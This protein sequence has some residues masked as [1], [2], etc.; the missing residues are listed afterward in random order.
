M[1]GLIGRV[2][3]EIGGDAS[4]L[5]R[6]AGEAQGALSKLQTFAQ[7]VSGIGLAILGSEAAVRMAERGYNAIA[8]A[9]KE[10]YGYTENYTYKVRD[11]NN[12]IGS[13]SEESSRFIQIADDLNITYSELTTSLT[14]AI[15]KGYEPTISGLKQISRE[16]KN[17]P[18]Q[19]TRSKYALDVFGRS[20]A[21]MIPI[22]EL[23]A[24]GIDTYSNNVDRNLILTDAQIEKN[25]RLAETLDNLNDQMQGF[26]VQ[27]VSEGAPFLTAFLDATKGADFSSSIDKMISALTMQDPGALISAFALAI[28]EANESTEEL[29]KS[30]KSLANGL[31]ADALRWTEAAENSKAYAR[32]QALLKELHPEM[33]QNAADIKQINEKMR[34]QAG[35]AGQ[36]S[37]M[38]EHYIDV[39]DKYGRRSWRTTEAIDGMKESLADVFYEMAQAG[40]IEI[41]VDASLALGNALGVVDEKSLL[42]SQAMQHLK[43]QY[44]VNKDGIIDLQ[45]GAAGY[46]DAV[47]QLIAN[48]NMLMVDRN[49]IWSI[50]MLLNGVKM[51]ASFYYGP[52]GKMNYASSVWGMGPGGMHGGTFTGLQ[53]G[54]IVPPGFSN[55]GMPIFVSS[56]ER[57]E[58]TPAG[59]KHIEGESNTINIKNYGPVHYHWPKDE[60]DRSLMEQLRS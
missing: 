52:S 45:E 49:A 48:A 14:Q 26:K 13:S 32:A 33:E 34:L 30:S 4:G 57:V 29:E 40:D 23:G 60:R 15:K 39:L 47:L 43:E 10:A 46:N 22:L 8:G 1:S 58:V 28:Q 36:L 37:S 44:D 41:A 35:I 42:V 25:I 53:H 9:V 20:G 31:R 50:T 19:I 11:L 27:A 55:D 17:L 6:A 18:D 16:Y 54:G 51:P 56:G 38:Q 24:A 12:L 5:K 59:N 21:N 2:W 7:G 3:A